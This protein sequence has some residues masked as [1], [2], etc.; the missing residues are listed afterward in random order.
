MSNVSRGVYQKCAEEN[1]KLKKDIETLVMSEGNEKYEC[2][3]K[4]RRHFIREKQSNELLK[5]ACKRY[6]KEHKDELSDFLTSVGK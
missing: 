4:W 1:K 2:F 6:V 5:E 3:K